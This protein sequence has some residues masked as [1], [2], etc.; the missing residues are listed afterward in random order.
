M[1]EFQF[2]FCD[3]WFAARKKSSYFAIFLLTKGSRNEPAY[4]SCAVQCSTV[5]QTNKNNRRTKKMCKGC[6]PESGKGVI[7][8]DDSGTSYAVVCTM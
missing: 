5:L 1:K 2:C 7:N 6:L 8:T 4:K 3:Q